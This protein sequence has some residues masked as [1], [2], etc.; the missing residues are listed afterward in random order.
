MMRL[1]GDGSPPPETCLHRVVQQA[2]CGDDVKDWL[3]VCV[4]GCDS[5]LSAEFM[6]EF[7]WNYNIHYNTWEQ[8]PKKRTNVP[9]AQQL[10]ELVD[11]IDTEEEGNV[12]LYG[13]GRDP[14]EQ[15]PDVSW[16]KTHHVRKN[17]RG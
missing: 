14:D 17:E 4:A 8:Q 6:L 1:E 2:I 16:T 13:N 3:I 11:R 10:T 5:T 12:I 15:P 9:L 7:E